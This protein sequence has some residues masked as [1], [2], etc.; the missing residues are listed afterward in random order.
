ML[1][2]LLL[3]RFRVGRR[4]LRA[5]FFVECDSKRELSLEEALLGTMADK[6]AEMIHYL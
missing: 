1:D 6:Y 3:G 4:R 5:M 2:G